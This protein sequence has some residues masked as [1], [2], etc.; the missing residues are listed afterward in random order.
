MGTNWEKLWSKGN[1]PKPLASNL[2]VAS[3]GFWYMRK[4]S[5]ESE[6]SQEAHNKLMTGLALNRHIATKQ[7]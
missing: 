6:S 7:Y 4:G 2:H 1:L 3:S 5:F